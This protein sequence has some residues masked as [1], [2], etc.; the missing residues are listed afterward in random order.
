MAFFPIPGVARYLIIAN[1]AMMKKVLA[2][3]VLF[4]AGCFSLAAQDGQAVY[5][6]PKEGNFMRYLVEDGDT[7][8][9]A[10]IKP[11]YCT[12]RGKKGKN[13]REYYRLVHNFGKVYNYAIEAGRIKRMIDSTYSASNMGSR[14]KEKYINAIQEDLLDKYEPI[15]RQMTF[16]QGKLLISLI[17][18]E[19]GLTPY[20]I[21]RDYKNGTAAAFW[22]GIAKM[23]EGD[24]KR[25]Y[26]PTGAD[27]QIEDLVEIWNRGE[28]ASVYWSIFGKNPEIGVVPVKGKK[29]M[30][31]DRKAARKAEREAEKARK[32]AEKAAR[33]AERDARR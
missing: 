25:H 5:R 14:A 6:M 8:Y 15:L 31:Q 1:F 12:A 9:I 32:A 17:D 21:I 7:V 23:F 29:E 24:L 20:E 16:S 28:Y 30:A 33:K 3:V 13:W 19:T 2:Y 27:A 10:H 11:S 18:R 22:Q 4:L 26:D